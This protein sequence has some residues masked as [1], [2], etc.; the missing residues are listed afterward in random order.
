LNSVK[1]NFLKK[2]SD[3]IISRN[4]KV[5]KEIIQLCKDEEAEIEKF[6]RENTVVEDDDN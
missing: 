2:L 4:R 6:K 5:V 3:R 1:G